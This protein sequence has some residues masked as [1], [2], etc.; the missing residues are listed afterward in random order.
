MKKSFYS[1]FLLGIILVTSGCNSTSKEAGDANCCA[2]QKQSLPVVMNL[3]RKIKP[4]FV[5]AFRDS[6]EKCRVG[7]LQE[8]GC[9]NYVMYQSYTDSTEFFIT[10]TWGNKGEHLKHMETEHLKIHLQEI[11]GMSDQSGGV[12]IYVCPHVND[13]KF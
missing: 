13:V 1:L 4:E 2:D 10:E 12:S 9:L 11:K 5:S 3:T 6:F 8:P 7:T